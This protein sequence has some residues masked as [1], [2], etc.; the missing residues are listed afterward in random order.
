ASRI[1]AGKNRREG[2]I[3]HRVGY[4]DSAQI[5]GGGKIVNRVTSERVTVPQIDRVPR[6]RR[7]GLPN[8][9][10]RN[11]KIEGLAFSRSGRFANVSAHVAPHDAT[12]LEGIGQRA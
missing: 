12:A 8:L 11:F 4:A 10:E 3:A 5:G 7:A 6:Q 1:A 2:R 9:H